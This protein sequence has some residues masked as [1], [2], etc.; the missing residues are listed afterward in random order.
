MTVAVV[1]DHELVV[2]GVAAMLAP[3]ADRVAVV[4]MDT[5]TSS[6]PAVDIVLFDTSTLEASQNARTGRPCGEPWR[7]G[8]HPLHVGP[9]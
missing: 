6:G 2:R 7:R 8:G 4:E 3:Y 1:D 5:D 9:Y